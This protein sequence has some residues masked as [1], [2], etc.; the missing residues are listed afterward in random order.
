MGR[1]LKKME[2]ILLGWKELYPSKGV[3]TL[4]KS[5]LSSL[6]TFFLSLF[7]LPD[8]NWSSYNWIS[9]QVGFFLFYNDEEPPQGMGQWDHPWGANPGSRHIPTEQAL[10]I[11][12]VAL[13]VSIN[14]KWDQ[15]VRKFF[16]FNPTFFFF[17]LVNGCGIMW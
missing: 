8:K 17:F 11:L 14:S 13:V 15:G 1:H 4:I 12:W 16:I 6:P 7:P 10:G 5:M 9:F 3:L 2:R